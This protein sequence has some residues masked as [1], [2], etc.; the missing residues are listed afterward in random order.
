MEERAET[1]RQRRMPRY[2]DIPQRPIADIKD[3][4]AGH[5]SL[6]APEQKEYG[7]LETCQKYVRALQVAGETVLQAWHVNVVEQG[8]FVGGKTPEVLV[9]TSMALIRLNHDAERDMVVGHD[10]RIGMEGVINI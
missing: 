6:W 3:S 2:F 8:V 5:L 7:F 1:E 10:R 4:L 9:L